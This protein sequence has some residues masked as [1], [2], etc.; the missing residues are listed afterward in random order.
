MSL[1]FYR[2]KPQSGLL[3]PTFQEAVPSGFP[4]PAEDHIHRRL[5]LNEYLID[6]PAS[7]FFATVQ[8]ESMADAGIWDDD[9]LIID[10]SIIPRPGH[11]VVAVVNGEFT[12]KRLEKT[13]TGQKILRAE[14]DGFP[15]I[16]L[17]RTLDYYLWGVVAHSVRTHLRRR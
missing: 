11:I 13:P 12:V 4:S 7:T 17:R 3:I 2:F 9:L 10:R 16:P 8:G 5:C 14:N 1:E 15:A 6:H